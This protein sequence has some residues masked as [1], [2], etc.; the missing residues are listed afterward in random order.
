MEMQ[1]SHPRLPTAVRDV[2]MR[3]RSAPIWWHGS[4]L[5]PPAMGTDRGIMHLSERRS[6]PEPQTA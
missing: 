4:G 5:P 2:R 3:A 6:A 1:S